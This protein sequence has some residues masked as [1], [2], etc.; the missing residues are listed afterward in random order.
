MVR[1]VADSLASLPSGFAEAHD[2]PV[3]PQII[4]FG[5]ES[6]LENVEMDAPAFMKKLKTSAEQPKTAAPPPELFRDCFAR[7]IAEGAEAI[8]S[9]HSST[10]LSGTVRSAVV[11]RREFPDHDIRVID[12]RAIAAPL[13]QIV[14]KAVGWAEQ[15]QDAAA[16][17]AR[18]RE[19][20]PCVRIYF[21]V[22]TLEYLQRG[23]RIGGAAALLGSLLQ[24][25][26]ILAL[27]DG[28]IELFERQRTQKRAYARLKEIVI[29]EMPRTQDPMLSVMHADAPELALSFAREL[30]LE[31][32]EVDI[33]I[34]D[35]VPAIVTHSGPGALV[36]SFFISS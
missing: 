15:K 20:M 16:I 30:K 31:L 1:I 8:L 18:V 6:Y 33:Y 10:D 3:I 28:R 21:L 9:I 17:E 11:A 13:A 35:L 26:P 29:N 2:L 4:N 5:S 36:V 22:D 23:G 19:L 7:L 24:V 25:K 34:T 27:I 12:T 32:G 14:M